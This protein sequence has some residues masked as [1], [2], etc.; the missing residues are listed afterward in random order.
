MSESDIAAVYY[1]LRE[2]GRHVTAMSLT[3]NP[4]VSDVHAKWAHDSIEHAV[5][6]LSSS[7]Q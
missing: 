4:F 1:F 7:T 2:A 5:T 3:T 6:F